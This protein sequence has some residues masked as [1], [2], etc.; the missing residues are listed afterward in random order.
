MH[1]ENVLNNITYPTYFSIF[2]LKKNNSSNHNLTE[3]VISKKMQNWRMGVKNTSFFLDFRNIKLRETWSRDYKTFFM[4]NSTELEISTAHKKLKY[5]Q[6][7]N[8]F[9]FI[10]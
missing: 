8:S 6:A 2:F 1:W 4:L 10:L 3:T 5:R 9:T 7:N